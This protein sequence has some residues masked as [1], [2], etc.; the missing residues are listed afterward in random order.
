MLDRLG[1]PLRGN[2][3]VLAILAFYNLL[4]DVLSVSRANTVLAWLLEKSVRYFDTC[5]MD[6]NSAR[7]LIIPAAHLSPRFISLSGFATAFDHVVNGTWSFTFFAPNNDA[8]ESLNERYRDWLV[9]PLGRDTIGNLLIH[10]YVPNTKFM[11]S[12]FNETYG[13]FQTGSYL[14]VGAQAIDNTV[15]LNRVAHIVEGDINVD[16]GIVHIIDRVLSPSYQEWEP[17]NARLI[18]QTF[19]PG[20]CSNP[21]LPYC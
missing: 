13:R 16:S 18:S 1:F 19:I 10:H 5:G 11:T 2:Y 12:S 9:S 21:A 4:N 6:R 8:I 14:L 3:Y 17:E 7:L 15:V 20:S